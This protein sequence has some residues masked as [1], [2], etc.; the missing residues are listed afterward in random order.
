MSKHHHRPEV[1]VMSLDNTGDLSESTKGEW[2]WEPCP[3]RASLGTLQA[4]NYIGRGL[5]GPGQ[6]IQP[7]LLSL[8]C[9]WA[10]SSHEE[11]SFPKEV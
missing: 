7:G 1:G 9:A 10:V 5:V 4:L 3:R 2:G 6:R 11:D 8:Q